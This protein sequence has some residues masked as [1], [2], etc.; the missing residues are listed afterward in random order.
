[1]WGALCGTIWSDLGFNRTDVHVCLK[2][3]E[4]ISEVVKVCLS[5]VFSQWTWMKSNWANV[6]TIKQLHLFSCWIQWEVYSMLNIK[7]INHF[8]SHW[9]LDRKC[10]IVNILAFGLIP[11]RPQKGK[12]YI[13]VFEKS[14]VNIL[15]TLCWSSGLSDE[16]W[17]SLEQR[18]MN[19]G[20]AMSGM[21]PPL[22]KN[23]I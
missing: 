17:H 18:T 19:R 3:I 14:L 20:P 15:F 1:M 5:C 6:H 8:N 11:F 2:L 4:V 21:R 16:A 9:E 12:Y 13:C 7:A 23:A 22:G 10:A